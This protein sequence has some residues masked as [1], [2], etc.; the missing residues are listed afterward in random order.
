L[1]D[2]QQGAG[3]LF[4]HVRGAFTGA[5]RNKPGLFSEANGGTLF[6]DDVSRQ[7]NSDTQRL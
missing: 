2:L 7:Q 3:E 1:G 4:G 5:D 6:L